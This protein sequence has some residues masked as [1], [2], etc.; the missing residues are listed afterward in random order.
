[1]VLRAETPGCVTIQHHPS[2]CL[3][4]HSNSSS[5]CPLCQGACD[6]PISPSL[7]YGLSDSST[8]PDP[9]CPPKVSWESITEP[10]CSAGP[11]IPTL[12]TPTGEVSRLL[13][14]PSSWIPIIPDACR[15]GA[16]RGQ[17]T[18]SPQDTYWLDGLPSQD[19]QA[20]VPHPLWM[21]T[22]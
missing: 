14:V 9:I 8:N 16:L 17:G 4:A 1:M 3:C 19:T 6:H 5:G 15:P 13:K 2:L 22:Y 7:S 12:K 10:S 20:L 11:Q 21:P 18:L